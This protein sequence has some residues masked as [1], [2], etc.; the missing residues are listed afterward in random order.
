MYA[1]KAISLKR[2]KM[3]QA[4][5]QR[6]Y[7][8]LQREAKIL[9]NLRHRQ[10]TSLRHVVE[11]SDHLFLVMELVQDGELFDKIVD[12]NI[13]PYKGRFSEPEGRFVLNQV[14]S[15]LSYV[16]SRQIVHRDLKPENILVVR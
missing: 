9:S 10:I 8:K 11:Q 16:H 12:H 3:Q 14:A 2:L 1:V 13:A 7:K 15:G 4:T 5:F 6:E